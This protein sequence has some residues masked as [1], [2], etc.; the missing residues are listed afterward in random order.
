[1]TQQGAAT[2]EVTRNVSGVHQSSSES[3]KAASE[4]LG[5]AGELAQQSAFLS[6]QVDEFLVEVRAM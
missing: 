4:V 6:T 5:A 2:E 3:G 1:M